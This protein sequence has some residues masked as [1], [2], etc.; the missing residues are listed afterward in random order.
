MSTDADIL[1]GQQRHALLGLPCQ[2]FDGWWPP[3]LLQALGRY[4]QGST[5]LEHTAPMAT[6]IGSIISTTQLRR[7]SSWWSA[8]RSD[9]NVHLS[10]VE[11]AYN[12]VISAASGLAPNQVHMNR[13]PRFRMTIFDDNPYARDHQILA[14]D[15]LES[16]TISSLIA[17]SRLSSSSEKVA[18]SHALH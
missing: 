10:Q 5:V 7:Y 6:T 13:L 4:R 3:I 8:P 16:A 18:L 17:N 2:C 12:N 14:H 15:L 9:W 11:L 1:L